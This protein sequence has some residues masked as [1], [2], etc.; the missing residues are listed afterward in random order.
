MV[1]IPPGDGTRDEEGGIVAGE[2]NG[3]PSLNVFVGNANLCCETE[4]DDWDNQTVEENVCE[5]GKAN[6]KGDE[7]R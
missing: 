5:Y 7:G 2:E 4:G 3:R 6:G 1:S